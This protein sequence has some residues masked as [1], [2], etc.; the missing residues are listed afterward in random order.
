VRR[1]CDLARRHGHRR[2]RA[3]VNPKRRLVGAATRLPRA[4]RSSSS[5]Q[6]FRGRC[7][8]RQVRGAR[9][10]HHVNTGGS[11]RG[12]R[13]SWGS[14]RRRRLTWLQSRYG[15]GASPCRR[16]WSPTTTSPP[17]WTRRRMDRR[18]HRHP[19]A[20]RSGTTSGLA[21]EAQ[22]AL[23]KAGLTP[24]TSTWCGR[25]HDARRPWCRGRPRPCRTRSGSTGAPRP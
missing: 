4:L 14:R 10:G 22:K 8:A 21:I 13:H 11:S 5:W 16:R 7:G 12:T 20:P 19:G 23:D 1:T 2:Q 15:L 3:H 24:A 9:L 6:Q 17:P 18:A 25:H